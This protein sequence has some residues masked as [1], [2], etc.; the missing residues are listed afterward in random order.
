MK[1]YSAIINSQKPDGISFTELK[2]TTELSA[3]SLSEYLTE[4]QNQG[5]IIKDP[6]TRQYKLAA[7]YY[8]SEAF[9]TEFQ[10][11]LKVFAVLVVEKA[12]KISQIRDKRTREEAFR[13]FLESIFRYYMVVVW[14]VIGEG[15]GVFGNNK[16]NL[17][18][19]DLVVN[20]NATINEGFQDWLIP[21]ANSVAMAIGVNIDVIKV[22]DQFFI[23]VAKEAEK[24]WADLEA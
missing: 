20:M 8:P 12:M 15:V 16:E 13:K 10:K 21:I 17:K 2:R 7:I 14:K 11:I 9:P 3:P 22:S 1:I 24:L 18:N 23:D 5:I 6:K 4:F 19:Q